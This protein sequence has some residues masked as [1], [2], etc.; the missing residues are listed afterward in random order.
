MS[1]R[2]SYR[3]VQPDSGLKRIALDCDFYA[4][5]LGACD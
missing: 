3:S 2:A 5:G 1:A 4:L